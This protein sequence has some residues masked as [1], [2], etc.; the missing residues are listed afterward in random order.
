MST[1]GQLDREERYQQEYAVSLA[2]YIVGCLVLEEVIPLSDLDKASSGADRDLSVHVC[3]D[4]V[5]AATRIIAAC[6]KGR[7]DAD[8]FHGV[9]FRW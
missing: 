1:D 3:P 2:A 5:D 9:P 8:E 7:L 6:L 4:K